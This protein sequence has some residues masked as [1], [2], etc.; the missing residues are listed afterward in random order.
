M[1]HVHRLPETCTYAAQ[2]AWSYTPHLLPQTLT[3]SDVL[4]KHSLK[5]ACKAM[6]YC[7]H[8]H[9]KLQGAVA[10]V[11]NHRICQGRAVWVMSGQKP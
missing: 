2:V 7:V 4:I 10:V 5:V 9:G 6:Q 3:Q 1:K 8:L 11:V